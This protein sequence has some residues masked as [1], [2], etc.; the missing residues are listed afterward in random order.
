MLHVLKIVNTHGI[1]GEVKA[2]HYTDGEPF[3]EAVKTV[4]KK[5]SSPMQ[6]KSWRFQK[7]SVLL[8]FDGIDDM[9]A[10]EKLRMT[11]L[12]AREEDLPE[13]GEGEYYF[14]E[15]TGL[16][17]V[18]PDGTVFGKSTGVIENNA[19]NLI[20]FEKENGRKVLIPN[21]PAF[22][23]KV[24]KENKKIYITPIQGLIDDEI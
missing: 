11:D 17:G 15:L 10:A 14:F 22:V 12:Y 2:L 4:Y 19:A 16:E 3:F 7:G 20:E 1:K 24:D 8:K 13:L 23:N 21:I 18:L 9:N 6:I 5:D